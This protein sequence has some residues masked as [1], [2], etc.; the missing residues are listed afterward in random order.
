MSQLETDTQPTAEELAEHQKQM[1][2]MLLGVFKS[3]LHGFM[4]QDN[5]HTFG[6]SDHLIRKQDDTG[7]IVSFVVLPSHCI[8]MRTV[9]PMDAL[10]KYMSF[11]PASEDDIIN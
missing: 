2:E 4:Q 3:Y 6:P 9:V 5:K 11:T 7:I 1:T 10:T 8:E